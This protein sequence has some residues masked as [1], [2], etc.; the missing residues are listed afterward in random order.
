KRSL[1]E[2][3]V[4]HASGLGNGLDLQSKVPN[5]QQQTRSGTNEGAGDKPKVPDVPEYRSESEEES[6]T[7]NQGEEEDEDDDEHNN[8]EDDDE[9][10]SDDVNEDNDDEDDDEDND[11]ERTDSDNDGDDFVH[12]KLSTYRADDQ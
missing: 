6:W 3:H 5:E 12:P 10:D 2:F 4:S 9:H 11:S 8:D 7:F 1:T